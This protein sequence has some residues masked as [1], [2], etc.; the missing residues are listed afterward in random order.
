M[1]KRFTNSLDLFLLVPAILVLAFAANLP[2]VAT[3]LALAWIA[4]LWL[5]RF[6]VLGRLSVSTP[7]DLPVAF[8]LVLLPLN[9]FASV[10]LGLSMPT[11]LRI[12]GEFTILYAIVNWATS[13]AQVRGLSLAL[14]GLGLI[15][16]V[17]SLVMTDL[18][19]SKL[20]DVDQWTRFLPRVEIPQ[21][22]PEG[23]NPN[24]VGGLAAVLLPLAFAQLVWGPDRTLRLAG[25]VGTVVLGAALVLTQSRGA[26]IAL[27]MAG[28]GMTILAF[29]RPVLLLT[30]VIGAVLVGLS[31][32][33]LQSILDLM[34]A[35][36]TLATAAGRVEG[37]Q[38]AVQMIRDFPLTGIGLGT[39][40]KAA[41]ILYPFFLLGP[42]AEV[43]HTHNIYLQAGVDQGIPGMVAYIGLVTVLLVTGI[44]SVRRARETPWGGLTLGLMGSLLVFLA[45]GMLDMIVYGLK[46]SALVWAL[47]GLLVATAR[48]CRAQVPTSRSGSQSLSVEQTKSPSQIH[49][50][51]S[52][53]KFSESA[54]TIVLWVVVSLLAVAIIRIDSILGLALII[55]GGMAVG[56]KS[57]VWYEQRTAI[58]QTPRALCRDD[59]RTKSSDGSKAQASEILNGGE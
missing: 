52:V 43:Y 54:Q 46:A 29:R 48:L 23:L 6:I 42:D 4:F 13:P 47:L 16:V 51:R 1:A 34:S 8:L 41:G 56:L 36:T 39:F 44:H 18:P 14:I 55:L 57:C 19:T 32:F 7:I 37:W 9:L 24:V 49:A 17:V 35:G 30:I 26:W 21:L 33:P 20:F 40:S 15:V 28:V 31:V 12:G 50:A 45:H 53:R 22:N 25:L 58:P 11:L 38:R 5:C 27:G 3:A 2:R 59:L 10:D